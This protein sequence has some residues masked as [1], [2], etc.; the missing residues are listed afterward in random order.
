MV[1][2][3]KELEELNCYSFNNVEISKLDINDVYLVKV[4]IGGMRKED[5]HSL[6]CNLKNKLEELGLTKVI[7]CPCC[8]GVPAL[9]IY[10][11]NS[12]D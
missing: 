12:E 5:A 2:S 1:W 8:D 11:L 6:C 10:K 3:E 7:I 9:S 4:E